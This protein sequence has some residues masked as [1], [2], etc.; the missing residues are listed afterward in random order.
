VSAD[1]FLNGLI[2][3][4]KSNLKKDVESNAVSVQTAIELYKAH[5]LKV[6]IDALAEKNIVTQIEKFEGVTEQQISFQISN[7]KTIAKFQ[8]FQ[9]GKGGTSLKFTKNELVDFNHLIEGFSFLKFEDIVELQVQMLPV[10]SQTASIQ[11]ENENFEIDNIPYDVYNKGNKKLTVIINLDSFKI[12]VDIDISKQPNYSLNS[13]VVDPKVVKSVNDGI[14][15]Y[16]LIYFIYSGRPFSLYINGS[17]IFLNK[18]I[19]Q[20]QQSAGFFKERVTLYKSLKRIEQFFKI[21]FK[22]INPE[23]FEKNFIKINNLIKLID[24]QRYF[25]EEEDGVSF[26]AKHFD[27]DLIDSLKK[28][29]YATKGV[30]VLTKPNRSINI[31]GIDLN[32]GDEQVLIYEPQIAAEGSD[33]VVIKSLDNMITYQYTKFGVDEI[34]MS[35]AIW[36]SKK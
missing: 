15:V 7:K 1:E 30:L 29:L 10:F 4:I 13:K 32:L 25:S 24:T 3:N 27:V 6:K 2:E 19:N 14:R 17:P 31:L 9:K 20:S 35:K 22:N 26:H 34:P 12:E 21:K 28:S 18:S 11:F 5:D 33:F 23:D 16:T 8:K 36:S